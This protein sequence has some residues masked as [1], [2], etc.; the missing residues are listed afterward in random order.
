MRGAIR[1]DAC[2]SSNPRARALQLSFLPV[3][4]RSSASPLAA[5][6]AAPLAS[7]P[8]AAPVAAP[9]A[10]PLAA[11]LAALLASSHAAETG[12]MATEMSNIRTG[13]PSL[14]RKILANAATYPEWLLGTGDFR[15]CP[16]KRLIAARTVSRRILGI[17]KFPTWMGN[18][19]LRTVR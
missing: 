4:Q 6:L 19:G 16:P 11:A 17:M 1:G 3:R 7:T 10:A 18:S 5:P 8:V 15:A 13:F 9:L 2:H 14:L 12:K